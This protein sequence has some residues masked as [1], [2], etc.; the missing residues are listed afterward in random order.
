MRRRSSTADRDRRAAP[1]AGAAPGRERDAH[2]TA[3]SASPRAVLEA[4]A[5]DGSTQAVFEQ[6]D[7]ATPLAQ[8][9]RQAAGMTHWRAVAM[10]QAPASAA[11]R[12]CLDHAHARNSVRRSGAAVVRLVRR[13]ADRC[14]GHE[15]RMPQRHPPRIARRRAPGRCTPARSR[16]ALHGMHHLGDWRID[17]FHRGAR[18]PPGR[19]CAG[20]R[21]C[22]R[23]AGP[24]KNARSRFT[25]RPFERREAR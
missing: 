8:L 25:L 14:A 19:R 12:S 18:P 13:A 11:P 21:T 10:T 7:D 2:S 16:P 24:H 17:P 23:R 9:R 4:A 5:T 3:S 20:A 15:P 22:R 1:A 6:W